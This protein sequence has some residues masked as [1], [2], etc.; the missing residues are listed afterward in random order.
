MKRSGFWAFWILLFVFACVYKID[1]ITITFVS[2][3]KPA[4][5]NP[6]TVQAAARIALS[7]P[8]LI[9]VFRA[10][11]PFA[12][13]G[14]NSFGTFS[15]TPIAGTAGTYTISFNLNPGFIL[16]GIFVFGGNQG[17]NFYA[18]NGQTSGSFVGPVS[19][20]VAGRSGTF[21]SLSHIDFLV[22]SSVAAAVPDDGTTFVMLG[23]AFIGLLGLRR[24]FK[25]EE[26][27]HF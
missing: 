13:G 26:W 6:T 14:T 15:I 7:D 18:I 5:E 8:N 10:E 19:A 3:Q 17:G 25:E 16:S 24:H 2:T 4:N 22:E 21:A 11:P 9:D 1:A 20:P 12:L 23:G 27:G